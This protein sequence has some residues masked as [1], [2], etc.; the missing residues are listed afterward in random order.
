MG[1]ILSALLLSVFSTAILFVLW[2]FLIQKRGGILAAFVGLSENIGGVL[3]PMFILGEQ[4]TWATTI[5]GSLILGAILCHEIQ[6]KTPTAS[7]S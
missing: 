7:I 3:F 5:G 1:S 2:F 6:W 4:M